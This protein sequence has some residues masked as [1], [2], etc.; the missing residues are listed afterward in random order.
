[1]LLL[2]SRG[3]KTGVDHTVPLLYL[4][5]GETIAVIASFGGRDHHP[6]WYLNLVADPDVTARTRDRSLRLMARTAN[7]AEREAWWPKVV[8]SYPDYATY[9]ARTKR[10]IPIVLLEAAPMAP[11]VT[12]A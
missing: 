9:Q 5:E 12:P 1:M 4:S 2:T 8:A 10:E 3:R 11:T 7:P 6:E